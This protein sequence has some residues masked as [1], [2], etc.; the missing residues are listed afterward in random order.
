[1]RS[2]SSRRSLR[3]RA[4]V[5]LLAV[6]LIV[7]P[8]IASFA[9]SGEGGAT[10]TV[11]QGPFHPVAGTFQPDETALGECG[12]EWT[13]LEQAFGNL[14]YREGPRSALARFEERLESDPNVEK[15]CHRIV[16]NIGS[17]VFARLDGDVAKTFAVGSAT[18]ASGYYHGVLERAF[19]GID[20]KAGLAKAARSLCLGNGM[21]R[22]GFLD[23]QCRHG[24]GHGLMIQ[25]GYDLPTAL[26]LCSRLGTRWD[27]VSC[28]GGAFMENVST[29]FGFRSRWLSDDQPLYPCNDVRLRYRRSCYLRVATW[30]L[31]LNGNDFE[32]AARTCESAGPRWSRFCF[33]GF[34]RDAVVE[35][36]YTSIDRAHALCALAGTARSQCFYGAARTFSDRGGKG[37]LE[38]AAAF[39]ARA[40][41]ADRD[42]CVSGLGIVLGL[43]HSTSASRR[44]ACM[45]LVPEHLDACAAAARAEV[46]PSGRESW[47]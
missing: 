39:C 15:D 25:T 13:C 37:D 28:T 42:H 36:R 1:M 35:A 40:P 24:L 32:Q 29:R 33:Q 45:R 27:E 10:A 22:R 26:A 16:H 12:G 5:A 18:C 43:L 30:V 6:P 41:R 14:A 38:R 23:Y 3:P 20:S 2:T 47:G 7:V 8:A 11:A 46:D 21:R 34:G 9:V 19:V 31:Q 17:A 4:L 44:A